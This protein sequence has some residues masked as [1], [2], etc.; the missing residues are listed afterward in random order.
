MVFLSKIETVKMVINFYGNV[1][2][3]SVDLDH[4]FRV[5]IRINIYLLDLKVNLDRSEKLIMDTVYLNLVWDL[6][7]D[8]VDKAVIGVSNIIVED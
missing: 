3:K 1:D 6:S 2:C 5:N 4:L 7:K 8:D